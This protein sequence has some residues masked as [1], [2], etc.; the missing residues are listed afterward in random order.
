MEPEA[1]ENGNKLKICPESILWEFIFSKKTYKAKIILPIIIE[2]FQASFMRRKFEFQFLS[3]ST[4]FGYWRGL[5]LK[6]HPEY[7]LRYQYH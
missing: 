7:Q 5:E 4:I 2:I 3:K 6:F 1:D